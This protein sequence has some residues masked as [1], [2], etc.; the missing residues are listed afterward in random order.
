MA[1]KIWIASSETGP[2]GTDT[3]FEHAYL[4][5]DPDGDPTSGDEQVFRGGPDNVPNSKSPLG[6]ITIEVW[7]D[8]DESADALGDESPSD[9]NYTELNTNGKTP[10]QIVQEFI[11]WANDLSKGVDGETGNTN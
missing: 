2:L 4:V 7:K 1:S 6:N 5:Y 11:D 3:G 10:E 8:I 9:R